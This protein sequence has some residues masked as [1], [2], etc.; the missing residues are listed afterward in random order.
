MATGGATDLGND[1][2]PIGIRT[3]H[4]IRASFALPAAEPP[5][6]D[7][8]PVH[9]GR[10]QHGAQRLHVL[11]SQALFQRRGHLKR[12][13]PARRNL[14]GLTRVGIAPRPSCGFFHTERSQLR[15]TGGFALRQCLHQQLQHRVHHARAVHLGQ[16]CLRP[17]LLNQLRFGE[18]APLCI[19]CRR[20]V[21]HRGGS[22]ERTLR[23][24][25]H[26]RSLPAPTP[27]TQPAS[28]PA[29]PP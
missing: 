7:P 17:Y 22:F 3:P 21:L 8:L 23:L 15:Q 18:F 1:L 10:E 2:A 5:A 12:D 24:L 13:F 16:A 11:E 29:R 20:G 26:A 14:H 25:R 4:G 27:V 6:L 9:L 28:P 19:R